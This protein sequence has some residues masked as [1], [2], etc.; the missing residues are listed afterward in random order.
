MH[1][2]PSCTQAARNLFKLNIVSAHRRLL[3][4][5]KSYAGKGLNA[6][7]KTRNI[8][9]D[10]RAWKKISETH[11]ITNL[12][13]LYITHVHSTECCSWNAECP[14]VRNNMWVCV[15]KMPSPTHWAETSSEYSTWS[16]G[17]W[18][19]SCYVHSLGY[20]STLYGQHK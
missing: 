1:Y 8:H 5:R 10:T 19:V 18:I 7:A 20:C 16:L 2:F 15:R 11:I 17:E 6:R 3:N 12:V 9:L 13:I 4:T 14:S